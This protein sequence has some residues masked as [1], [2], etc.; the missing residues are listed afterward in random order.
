MSDFVG[1][2]DFARLSR[3]CP[4]LKA[5]P[6]E[7][8][9]R[10][11]TTSNNR[12]YFQKIKTGEKTLT[13]PTKGGL[14]GRWIFHIRVMPNGAHQAVFYNREESSDRFSIA[15]PRVSREAASKAQVH[16]DHKRDA[17]LSQWHRDKIEEKDI[18][19][20]FKVIHTIDG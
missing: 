2:E 17:D 11:D 8:T 15:D 16:V 7:W 13:H 10:V 1:Q 3:T 6:Q 9:W 5:L 12:I 20:K 14:P 18:S 4:E 19:Y